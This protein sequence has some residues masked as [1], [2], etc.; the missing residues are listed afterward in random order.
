MAK[1]K[2]TL[3]AVVLLC[4]IITAKIAFSEEGPITKLFFRS[5]TVMQCDQVWEG[6]GSNI[7]CKKSRGILAY[8]A[9]EIDLVKTFGEADAKEI[10]ARYERIIKDRELSSKPIIITPEQERAMRK[11][12]REKSKVDKP[13]RLTRKELEK[14]FKHL[15]TAA[16]AR[17]GGFSARTREGAIASYLIW[18]AKHDYERAGRKSLERIRLERTEKSKKLK[19][20]T[21]A[22]GTQDGTFY[23]P[24]GN[25]GL[26]N[27]R[28][29]EII[30]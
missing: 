22:T 6:V 14:M 2:K 16:Q 15:P 23:A 8:S 28:T 4:L 27:T 13:A 18:Q 24:T 17:A 1:P 26:I 10:A 12:E 5:G 9:D 30:N 11:R 3:W 29:G 25:G 19:H 7:L 21:G 20:N